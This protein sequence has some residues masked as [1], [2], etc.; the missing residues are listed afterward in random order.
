MVKIR[1][2]MKGRLKSPFYR[3]VVANGKSNREGIPLEVLGYWDPKAKKLEI[4][5]DKLKS[6]ISKGAQITDG[7]KKLL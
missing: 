4:D 5:R 7:V 3:I 2:T 6:W 1:L